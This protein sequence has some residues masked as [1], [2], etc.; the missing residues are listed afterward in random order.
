MRIV[1]RMQNIFK[2]VFLG[3]FL[4]IGG[5]LAEQ[6]QM[7]GVLIPGIEEELSPERDTLELEVESS[8]DSNRFG[9]ENVDESEEI[10]G[11][12][13][14]W[15]KKR[16]WVEEALDIN[17]QIQDGVISI[18]KLSQGFQK[19]FNNVDKDLD[20]FYLSM[21]FSRGKI[22]IIFK[23]IELFVGKKK[24]KE[25]TFLRKKVENEDL[26][27]SY[28]DYKSEEIEDEV[29]DLLRD[30]KQLGL[31]MKSIEELDASL[32][33]RLKKVD[34]HINMSIKSGKD[35]SGITEEMWHFIDHRKA[36]NRFYD[37]RNIKE[38][39]KARLNY[40]ENDLT[41]DFDAVVVRIKNQ[42]ER[43]KK[44]I[45]DLEDRGLIIKHRAERITK[46]KEET[47]KKK[48]EKELEQEAQVPRRRRVQ[49]VE[50]RQWYQTIIDLI[51]DPIVSIFN[52]VGSFFGVAQHVS[53][54]SRGQRRKKGSK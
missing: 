31:D 11:D 42:I 54:K 26:S 14:N 48:L 16:K 27:E 15:V 37:I 34:E 28:R 25:I 19:K 18:Q 5:L 22:S 9:P 41:N 52:Y 46:I 20:S 43:V 49:I 53:Q 40:I 23:K 39:E 35:S 17:E 1:R 45:K 3:L 32:G 8:S 44:E 33:E 10:I 7:P 12:Q 2:V 47:R 13:G 51:I 4:I 21:G 38:Q 30:L 6:D 36:A 24:Q 50:S 29:K